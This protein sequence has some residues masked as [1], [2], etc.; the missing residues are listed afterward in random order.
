MLLASK[1]LSNQIPSLTWN[2]SGSASITFG[3]DV[4]IVHADLEVNEPSYLPELYVLCELLRIA[5]SNGMDSSQVYRELDEEVISRISEKLVGRSTLTG[6]PYHLS[7]T[8]FRDAE[9]FDVID[10]D[11][12]E[13]LYHDVIVSSNSY[14]A[15]RAGVTQEQVDVE[16]LVFE[17][18]MSCS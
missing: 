7:P 9:F 8:F 10:D 15:N 12:D 17:I 6:E 16:A 5:D 1:Q 13:G 2:S 14:L 11:L 3:Q 18:R 4:K